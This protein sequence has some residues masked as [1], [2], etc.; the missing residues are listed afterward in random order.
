MAKIEEGEAEGAAG[1]LVMAQLNIAAALIEE[2]EAELSKSE[3]EAPIA[4]H[5]NLAERLGRQVQAL[6][7]VLDSPTAEAAQAG[8][9]LRKLISRIVVSPDLSVDVDGRGSGLVSLTL[10]GRSSPS[11]PLAV[12][13]RIAGWCWVRGQDLNL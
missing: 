13:R 7:A 4:V 12:G 6:R 11:S 3:E 5:S 8:E 9:K 10:E 2:I 1:K